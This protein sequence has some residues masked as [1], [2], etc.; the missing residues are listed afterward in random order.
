M[1]SEAAWSEFEAEL[2][3]IAVRVRVMH[4]S[5]APY[6][7]LKP[8]SSTGKR[9]VLAT[10]PNPSAV[11]MATKRRSAR[12]GTEAFARRSAAEH[13]GS[14]HLTV[15]KVDTLKGWRPKQLTA[16]AKKEGWDH[17]ELRDLIEDLDTPGRLKGADRGEAWKTLNL[18]VGSWVNRD[19]ATTV[20]ARKWRKI[21]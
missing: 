16:W 15:T 11:Y 7:V 8:R 13:G 19:P 18:S 1:L 17:E 10:D 6:P 4:G 5:N 12:G 2:E 9:A 20:R 14:P 3:K 21:E